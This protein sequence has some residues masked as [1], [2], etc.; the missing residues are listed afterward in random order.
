MQVI[1]GVLVSL[2]AALLFFVVEP[3]LLEL[4]EVLRTSTSV[5]VFIVVIIISFVLSRFQSVFSKEGGSIGVG[6]MSKKDLDIEIDNVKT[7]G[8]SGNIA[9]RNVSGGNTKIK[10]SGSDI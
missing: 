3:M 2:A 10:I 8:G 7:H 1:I 5:L 9:S 4:D 6:N